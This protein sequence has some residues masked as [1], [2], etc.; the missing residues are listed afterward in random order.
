MSVRVPTPPAPFR[1]TSAI[2]GRVRV[3]FAGPLRRDRWLRQLAALLSELPMSLQTEEL[4]ESNSVIV[5]YPAE[6]HGLAEVMARVTEEV[7]CVLRV[8]Y[9]AKTEYAIRSTKYAPVSPDEMEVLHS[10][11]GRLRVRIPRL[12][13]HRAVAA[14]LESHLQQQRGVRSVAAPVDTE[15]LIVTYD[16][17]VCQARQIIKRVRRVL[18][19]AVRRPLPEGPDLH[20]RDLLAEEP[21]G[22]NPVLMPTLA[23]GVS[24]VAALPVALTGGALAL[25]ALPTAVRAWQ[26]ARGRQFNVDQLDLFA[27]GILGFM[28]QFLTA[29]VMTCLIG[30]GD[31]IRGR[32]ARRARRAVSELLS[33][34]GQQAWVERDG[35]VIGI[36]VDRLVPGD[37]VRVYPGDQIPADGMVLQGEALVDQKTLTGE[38]TPVPKREGDSVFALS[39]VADGQLWIRVEHIGKETRAGRVVELI[40]NAPLSDTRAQSWA[41]KVGNRLVGPIFALAGVTYLVT[42]D[43]VRVAAIVILDFVSGLRVSAPTTV[44]SAMTGAARQALFIKGG[45]A[46]EKLAEV[47]AL[48]FDKTGTLTRGEPFVTA[49]EAVDAVPWCP[50]E[51]LRLAAS[52][53]VNLKH[54]AAQAIVA[55]AAARSLAITPPT[56]ME[57][58]LGRGVRSE[59]EGQTVHAG[60]RRYL[61]E[62][63]VDTSAAAERAEMQ[64]Q[65]GQSL[66]YV[67]VEGRL[68]GWLAYADI[69]RG[70]SA[71]VIRGLLDRGVKRIV[72][73]TGDHARAAQ[74]VARELGIT[75]VVA[76]AFPEQK[77]EVVRALRQEGYTVGVIGDGINDSLAFTEA[78]VSIS[79]QH[80]ADVAKETADVILLDGDLRGL[81]RAVDLCRH[82]VRILHENKNIVFWPNAAGLVASTLGLSGPLL[83]TLINN[84]T[85]V[86]TGV[87]ALRP[88]FARPSESLS[89]PRL[90]AAPEA[91]SQAASRCHGGGGEGGT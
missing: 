45:R 27:I 12:R 91:A 48:V 15:F 33:P 34:Q 75:D 20:G 6:Q 19:E 23:L 43:L 70:E 90:L 1:I 78:D 7:H 40:E 21:G 77:A 18:R 79:L 17:C 37:I 14:E 13:R 82:A 58:S 72:L 46:L 61:E 76:D 51:V 47:N 57:Y 8:S 30:L 25:A 83:S 5:R 88:L 36:P 87:N 71:L 68:I 80:G 49:V 11:P 52:A 54:P 60:S 22:L 28:G 3:Q 2:P 38:S 10:F 62:L 39:F 63:G 29:S 86:L 69:P 65:A 55:A 85:A 24:A 66:V 73:L 53:E 4:P 64:R 16:T 50:D 44:L 31:Y 74:S 81:L 89:E 67:A 41:E 42:T 26:G 59:V 84:G 35:V 9:P 32:T 56:A